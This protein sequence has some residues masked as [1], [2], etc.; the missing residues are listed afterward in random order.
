VVLKDV[1]QWRSC[2]PVYFWPDRPEEHVSGGDGAGLCRSE[3]C[4]SVDC[5]HGRPEG[6]ELGGYLAGLWS[7]GLVWLGSRTRGSEIPWPVE[8]QLCGPMGWG[9]AC[10][11]SCSVGKLWYGEDFQELKVQRAEVL[12]LPCALP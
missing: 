4:R 11:T 1:G 7:S 3:G 5:W 9:F 2:G 12:A 10:S 8:Q 6:W